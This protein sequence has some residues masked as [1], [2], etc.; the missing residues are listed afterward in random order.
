MNHINYTLM[1]WK[2]KRDRSYTWKKLQCQN[3]PS[4]HCINSW[5]DVKVDMFVHS[6]PKWETVLC[7]GPIWYSEKASGTVA[8]NE[9]PLNDNKCQSE[10]LK[11]NSGH[12]GIVAHRWRSTNCSASALLHVLWRVP[13]AYLSVLV[14]PSVF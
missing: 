13:R 10:P 14:N 6:P 9:K 3:Q 8:Q 4:I 7:A 1:H 5:S 12:C 2:G 11:A